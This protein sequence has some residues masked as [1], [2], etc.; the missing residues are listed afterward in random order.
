MVG[1]QS[2]FL[3]LHTTL[4]AFL[5]FQCHFQ[6]ASHVE[7]CFRLDTTLGK[8]LL[9][10]EMTLVH[11]VATGQ[12]KPVQIAKKLTNGGHYKWNDN[13][14]SNNERQSISASLTDT[15][16][17]KNAQLKNLTCNSNHLGILYHFN[18]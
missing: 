5:S 2:L 1:N 13:L 10:Y 14:L 8:Y 4:V 3:S 18:K 17:L 15:E 11:L 9:Y 12:L 6:L 7:I 16:N